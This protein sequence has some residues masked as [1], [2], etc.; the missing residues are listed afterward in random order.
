VPCLSDMA[1]EVGSPDRHPLVVIDIEKL[2]SII[3]A[4]IDSMAA[5]S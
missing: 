3:I 4:N 5:T 2:L 1:K